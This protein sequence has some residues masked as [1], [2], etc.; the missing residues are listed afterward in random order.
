MC[1][2]VINEL[3]FDICNIL[4]NN[5]Y[6]CLFLLNLERLF[7]HQVPKIEDKYSDACSLLK[8]L[9]QHHLSMIREAHNPG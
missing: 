2:F 6:Y 5:T 7:A 4:F 8:R 9:R 1:F 3:M